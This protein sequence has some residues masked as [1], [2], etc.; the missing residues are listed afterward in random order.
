MF[1]NSPSAPAHT[2]PLGHLLLCF[3]FREHMFAFGLDRDLGEG[4]TGGDSA[5]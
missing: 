5:S 1:S 2:C 4:V 3:L